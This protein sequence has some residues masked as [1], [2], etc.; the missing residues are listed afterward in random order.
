MKKQ[1]TYRLYLE[2]HETDHTVAAAS[3]GKALVLLASAAGVTLASQNGRYG[4]TTDGRSVS[5]L[6]MKWGRAHY[7]DARTTRLL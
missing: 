3:P 2:S 4:K 7:S 1:S 5:A 6:T